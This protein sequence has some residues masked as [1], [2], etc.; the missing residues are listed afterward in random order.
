MR[1]L[2][3]KIFDFGSA[4]STWFSWFIIAQKKEAVLSKQLRSKKKSYFE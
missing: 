3:G 2:R 4:D 1:G